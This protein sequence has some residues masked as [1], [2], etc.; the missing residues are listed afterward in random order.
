VIERWFWTVR[1]EGGERFE[2]YARAKGALFDNMEVFY[3]QQRRHSRLGQIGPAEFERR[4]ARA[5]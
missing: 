1:S 4:A 2:S 3:N 5:A